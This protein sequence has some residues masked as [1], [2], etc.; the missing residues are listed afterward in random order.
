MRK[1]NKRVRGF[2]LMEEKAF[3]KI[4][5]L[6][7]FLKEEKMRGN[8]GLKMGWIPLLG[9]LLFL[10]FMPSFAQKTKMI[11]VRGSDTMVN[12]MQILAEEYMNRKPGSSIAVMGGGSGTGITALINGTCDLASTSREWRQREIDLAWERG[13]RPRFFVVA[14]DGLSL[15]VNEKN[16]IDKLTIAQVGA[17]YR[18]EI[19]NWKDVGGPNLPIVLYGRQSTSGTY[20]FMQELVL[21]NKNYSTEMR[22]MIGNAQIVEAV[23]QD[24]GGIGY[25][26]VGYVFDKDG[27]IRKGLKVLN[28]SKDEKSPAYSPLDKAAI[29]DGRYPIARPLYLATNGK[30]SP[31]IADFISFIISEEGQKIVE[32]EGFFTIGRQHREQNEKN[33]K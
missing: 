2:Q 8:F 31:A 19:R 16:P 18:G 3:K 17:I 29:D 13:V 24:Q 4:K 1:I 22:E 9:V 15:I 27:K 11:Q 33:L 28:I 25:V 5:R 23:I 10:I 7:S 12:M 21:G 20:V 26:G 6:N 30:P 14:I 32:R